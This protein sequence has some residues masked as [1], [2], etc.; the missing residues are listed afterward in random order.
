MSIEI[1]QVDPADERAIR[2]F[3]D[4]SVT[5]GRHDSVSFIATPYDELALVVRQPTEDFSYTAFLAYDGDDVVAEGWY[6]AFLRANLDKAIVRPRV[7]P[8]QRRRGLGSAILSRLEDHARADGRAIVQASPRWAMEHGPEGAGSPGVEFARKHG[9]PVRLVE[10]ERRL[11]LPVCAELLDE[12][13]ARAAPAY[14]I[15]A[16]SGSVPGELVQ[17][18]AELEASLPTEA[19]TGEVETEEFPPSVGSVRDAERLLMETGQVKYNAVAI[20]PD[21]ELAGYTDIV[22]RSQ[23]EPAEQW[24]TLVRRAHRG[25]GLGCGLKAA[26]IRL[27]QQER[28]E[29]SAT[30]TSNALTNTAMVAVNDRLGYE[31]IEYLGDVQKRL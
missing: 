19:P 10:A 14:E 27:L 17:G 29:I 3:Y 24:G 16:F 25:H 5:C 13:S 20:A 1:R 22:V 4:V 30:I 6:A 26:V 21:G 18:W 2:V 28:P 31:I 23:D 9:Y 15:R 11:A 8:R 7:L 12:L